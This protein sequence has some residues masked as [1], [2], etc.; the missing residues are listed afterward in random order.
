MTALYQAHDV[1][2]DVLE[3][4]SK[5]CVII[6]AASWTCHPLLVDDRRTNAAG[7]F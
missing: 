5:G 4:A 1:G 2:L 6:M 7:G 3:A